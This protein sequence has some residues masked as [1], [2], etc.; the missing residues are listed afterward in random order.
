[1]HNSTTL[2]I[3][4]LVVVGA[5]GLASLLAL[6][7]RAN[8][9][10]HEH[11]R[12]KRCESRV[13]AT[14]GDLVDCIR[15]ER[16][17]KRMR[18]FERI[19]IENPGADGHPSRNVGEPGYKASVDY[20]AALMMKAG[21]TV[22]LQ[23]FTVPYFSV[24]GTPRFV[25]HSPERRH[26]R[27]TRDWYVAYNS[28]AGTVRAQVQPVGGIVVPATGISQSGC[29]AADFAGFVTG[30][31][32]LIQRGTCSVQKKVN[33]ATGAGATA[34]II[35]NGG[36]SPDQLAPPDLFSGP[37][38]SIP[39]IATSYEVGADLYQ[40]YQQNQLPLVELEVQTVVDPNRLDYN[41]I[42]DSP[43]GDPDHV[44]TVEAHLDAIFGAG[45]L[46]N[47]SGSVTILETALQMAHTPTRNHLRFIWF[48]G[49]EIGLYGSWFYVSSLSSEDLGKIVF[50]IDSDVTATPNFNVW[51]A[52]PA[53]AYYAAD[54]PPNVVSASQRG[55]QY[56]F[57]Y[58]NSIGLAA[59]S[60][61]FGNDGT[62]SGPFSWYGIP[63]TG[64]LTGQD[65]CKTAEDVALWGG[66]PGNFE[67]HV[68]GFD[69]GCV[70][71]EGRWC[72]NLWNADPDVLEMISKA[73]A[74][75]TFKLANDTSL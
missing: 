26:F 68:P 1:M 16:L 66:F 59:R 17:W 48:G 67:G 22:T 27:I 6:E 38:T 36:N 29:S 43:F 15:R 8:E 11:E 49:E 7:A 23:T 64:I 57:D 33:L 74:Y 41:L 69:G 60:A 75:V 14:A 24:V 42:A 30:R 50:D 58:F 35:F 44:V 37:T 54:F 12:E 55:N 65:C 32:A 13:H 61:P 9:R 18:D 52:D 53:N 70:D 62:D 71:Y 39:V 19:A 2:A 72:D 3:R 20:V 10:E 34:V 21:Y 4:G 73:F 46:D 25:Q 56:F 63:N 31:I 40:R 45:I 28:A 47:A 51:V 5:A